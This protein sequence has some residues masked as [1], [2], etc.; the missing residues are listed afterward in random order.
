M[1]K[2]VKTKKKSRSCSKVMIYTNNQGPKKWAEQLISY[3]ETKIN[4]KLFDQIVCAFKINGKQIE[5]NR[6]THEKTHSDFIKCTKMPKDAHICYLDDV[7]F[8]EM[9]NDNIYYI[10][11]K[12]YT[13][14]LSFDEMLGRYIKS[15]LGKKFN[16]GKE[17]KKIFN[18][19]EHKHTRKGV[20]DMEIDIILGKEIMSHLKL[21]FDD[22]RRTVKRR[23]KINNRTKKNS[24]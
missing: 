15:D 11:L 4:Y 18:E 6:T 8:P 9:V 3:F 5:M 12:P 23:R 10:H 1:C 22:N 7:Y 19:F 13:H 24:V 16:L 17:M 21:F 14:E 20:G 2:G